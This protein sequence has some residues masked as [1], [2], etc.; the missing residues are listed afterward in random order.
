MTKGKRTVAPKKVSKGVFRPSKRQ[1]TAA[2][3]DWMPL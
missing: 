1:K 2:P 3:A